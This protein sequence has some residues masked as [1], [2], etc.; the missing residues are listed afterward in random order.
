[1][2]MTDVVWGSLMAAIVMDRT[3]KVLQSSKP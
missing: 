1:L 3:A 2:R